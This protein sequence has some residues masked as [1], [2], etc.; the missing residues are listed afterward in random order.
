MNYF[1]KNKIFFERKELENAFIYHYI[2]YNE[3]ITL[4]QKGAELIN[5]TLDEGLEIRMKYIFQYLL[6]FITISLIFFHQE[7]LPL[8]YIYQI[9]IVY[10]P[11][12]VKIDEK[13]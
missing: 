11:K 12:Y 9:E 8:F 5:G 7:T 2:L 6:L 10:R 3:T 4:F 13:H 1:N